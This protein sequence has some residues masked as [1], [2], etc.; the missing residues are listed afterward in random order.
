MEASVAVEV[1]PVAIEAI[2]ALDERSPSIQVGS[3]RKR[4]RKEDEALRL[5]ARSERKRR[6]TSVGLYHHRHRHCHRCQHRFLRY[7]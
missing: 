4:P 7:V 6:A 3:P 5:G 1:S 2:A